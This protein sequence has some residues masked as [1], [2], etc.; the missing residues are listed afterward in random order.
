MPQHQSHGRVG[1]NIDS[2]LA[3]LA[4]HIV[5]GGQRIALKLPCWHLILGFEKCEKAQHCL[6]FV[7]F[8]QANKGVLQLVALKAP[9]SVARIAGRQPRKII[10]LS[11]YNLQVAILSVPTL[12]RSTCH[13]THA[14]II[15]N[16]NPCWE[17]I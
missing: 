1:G 10:V 2:A 14:N 13:Y 12:K 8:A 5:G 7:K 17:P 3:R 16:S 6:R 9:H 4:Q 11:H 15:S